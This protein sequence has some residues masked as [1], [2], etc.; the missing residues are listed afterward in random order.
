MRDLLETENI[1]LEPSACAAFQGPVYMEKVKSHRKYL[2]ENHL[3]DKMKKYNTY[4][5]G[6]GWK[7]CAR[8]QFAKNIET[9]I[10]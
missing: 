2:L 1:F 7:P 6:N 8:G 5:M 9:L 4:C 10:R 3:K